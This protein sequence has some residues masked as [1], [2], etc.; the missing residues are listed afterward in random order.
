LSSI[1]TIW[2]QLIT[3]IRSTTPFSPTV[4]FAVLNVASLTCLVLRSSV[5]KV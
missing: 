2:Y 1:D 4:S 5:Q 3:P